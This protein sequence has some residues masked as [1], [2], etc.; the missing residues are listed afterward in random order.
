[1]LNGNVYVVCSNTVWLPCQ[2]ETRMLNFI[3]KVSHLLLTFFLPFSLEKTKIL[4]IQPQNTFY[5]G[6]IRRYW[7]I[8][9][10]IICD[11]I[12]S[13]CTNLSYNFHICITILII[14]EEKKSVYNNIIFFYN[15]TINSFYVSKSTYKGLLSTQNAKG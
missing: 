3:I 12:L 15:N 13:A 5:I 2:R 9:V 8:T 11:S 1:M 10:T 6:F 4:F 14:I 7:W